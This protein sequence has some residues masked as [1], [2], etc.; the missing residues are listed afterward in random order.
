MRRQILPAIGLLLVLSA[1]LGIAYPVVVWGIGQA[2]FNS[3]VNG[4]FVKS[5]G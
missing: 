3:K 2:A 4:S 1:L 5:D